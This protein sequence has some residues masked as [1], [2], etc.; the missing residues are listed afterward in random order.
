MKGIP[1]SFDFLRKT[2]KAI[3]DTDKGT[4]WSKALNREIEV[5]ITPKN[6]FLMDLVQIWEPKENA[7][8]VLASQV[9]VTSESQNPSNDVKTKAPGFA[10]ISQSKLEANF[11]RI[12]QNK[13]MDENVSKTH[14]QHDP[15]QAGVALPELQ[16]Q[17]DEHQLASDLLGPSSD[18][19]RDG[20]SYVGN[21]HDVSVSALQE[22]PEEPQDS[23]GLSRIR[24]SAADD[25]SSTE[26]GEDRVRQVQTGNELR[27]GFHRWRMDG[28]VHRELR[29]VREGGTPEIHPLRRA[30]S[31]HRDSRGSYSSPEAATYI[32]DDCS[33]EQGSS[34]QSPEGPKWEPRS[35]RKRRPS[36]P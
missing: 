11:S 32:E 27:R 16:C 30:T 8:P 24:D 10:K 29:E 19:N 22:L 1:H 7:L 14:I 17:V 2:L 9:Q 26:S 21:T 36:L 6:L 5:E 33:K 15:S 3:I 13:D 4:I 18:T 35:P 31:G 25:S 20:R 23:A 28:L 12:P 34:S